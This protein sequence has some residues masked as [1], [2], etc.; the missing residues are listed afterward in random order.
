MSTHCAGVPV[1]GGRKQAKENEKNRL[2]IITSIDIC[3]N[4]KIRLQHLGNF[5][6]I[7][8][9]GLLRGEELSRMIAFFTLDEPYTRLGDYKDGAKHGGPL[10]KREHLTLPNRKII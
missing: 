7:D 10:Y 6:C 5:S 8:N 9:G 3:S 4:D 2:L 1:Y